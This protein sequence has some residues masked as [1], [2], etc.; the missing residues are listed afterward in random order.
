MPATFSARPALK[1]L[2]AA[3]EQGLETRAGAQVERAGAFWAVDFM[4]GD[5]EEIHLQR[6]DVERQFIRCLHRVGV[7]RNA[8][9]AAEGADDSDGLHGAHL[10]IGIHDRDEDGLGREGRGDLGGSVYP[11]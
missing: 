11:S 4:R 3:I 8:A 10:V 5:G 1:L 9:R 2:A 7:K 6:I